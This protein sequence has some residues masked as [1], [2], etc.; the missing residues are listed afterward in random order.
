MD[1]PTTRVLAVL[2]LLQSEGRVTGPELARRVGVDVR[3]LRRYIARLDELGIPMT[4]E[5]GRYGCYALM[6][7]YKL[8]PMMFSNGEALALS[9]GLLAAQRLGV[10]Q[11]GP[12]AQ[13]A[14]AKLE[15]VMPARLKNRV[16][17]LGETVQMDIARTL[18]AG[19]GAAL[20]ALGE[21]A[22]ARQRVA[23]DY[24][25]AE[26][27]ATQRDV[28][29]YGL[30]MRNARW[31]AVGHCHL[32][33]GLRSFRIDR[34]RSVAPRLASFTP[35][36]DFDA[37]KHL[38]LGL[39]TLPRAHA[40]QVLLRTDL[41]TAHEQLFETIGVFQPVQGGLMLH[42]QVDD[43]RWLARQLAR[44]ECRFEV[45]APGKLKQELAR[46]ARRLLTI[47]TQKGL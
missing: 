30:A 44:L 9:I 39:A 6:P 5:R 33:A 25:S 34:V 41:A 36:A 47:S 17:A 31:Y 7:G 28:D 35:P 4:A 26:G 19:D 12:D 2:E 32:R 18:P 20:A 27:E 42:A 14:Q 15:R 40:A 11:A 10:A 16:R 46:H 24:L 43:L 45:I 23:I 22:H 8:P 38:A 37:V 1:S 29:V 21:A 13:S 3:T